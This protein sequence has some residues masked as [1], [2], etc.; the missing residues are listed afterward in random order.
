MS[1]WQRMSMAICVLFGFAYMRWVAWSE[2]SRFWLVAGVM[3]V[4]AI[5]AFVAHRVMAA[6]RRY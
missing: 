5:A 6:N 2:G 1:H 4:F 3:A